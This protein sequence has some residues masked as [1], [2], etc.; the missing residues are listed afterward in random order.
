MFV[1]VA[2]KALLGAAA[3]QP[4]M[5]DAVAQ[6]TRPADLSFSICLQ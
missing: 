4:K 6:N 2:A 5:C 1:F 3:R